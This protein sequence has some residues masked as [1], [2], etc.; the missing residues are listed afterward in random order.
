MLTP[1]L[2]VGVFAVCVM[3]LVAPGVSS[4]TYPGKPIRIITS[5]AGG[6]NDFQSRLIAP[7]LAEALGQPVIVENRGGG[8]ASGEAAS[9]AAPD[10]YTVL[11]A[12][13]THWQSPL[14]RKTLYDPVM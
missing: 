6:G 5:G 10:G 11:V 9:K 1:R 4:Q 3:V 14:L 12:G 13:T 8:V 2:V 7:A